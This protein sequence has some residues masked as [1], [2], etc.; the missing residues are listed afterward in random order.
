MAKNFIF[1]GI[2]GAGKTSATVLLS[3]TLKATTDFPVMP[4]REP[5]GTKVGAL[6]RHSLLSSD[7]GEEM[8]PTTR[9]LSYTADRNQLMEQVVF[10]FNRENPDGITIG[11]RSWP[12]TMALQKEDGADYEYTRLVQ[13]PYINKYP[14]KIFL[15]DIHPAEAGLRLFVSG[16]QGREINWRDK[17]PI[18]IYEA[19]RKNYFKLMNDYPDRFVL[20]DGFK[21]QPELVY[22][23]RNLVLDEMAKDELLRERVLQAKAEFNEGQI[24]NFVEDKIGKQTFIDEWYVDSLEELRKEKGIPSKVE[25]QQQMHQEW[26]DLGLGNL[27]GGKERK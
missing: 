10:P 18:E 3:E 19:H 9:M 4:V 11:D 6:I 22:E 20:L 27:G 16:K 13:T 2:E 21:S 7:V 25:L 8:H 15:I 5:G 23:A 26:E 12:S 24:K 1:E 14:T 17:L